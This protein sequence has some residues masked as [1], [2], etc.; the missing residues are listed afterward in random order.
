MFFLMVKYA[1]VTSAVQITNTAER[2]IL[3]KL[4][5]RFYLLRLLGCNQQT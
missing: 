3:K 2:S 4:E 1:A 5:I